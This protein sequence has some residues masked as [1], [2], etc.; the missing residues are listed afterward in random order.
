MI[1]LNVFS[2]CFL[3]IMLSLMG[4]W[5][6]RVKWGQWHQKTLANTNH[7]GFLQTSLTNQNANCLCQQGIN[8]LP[9]CQQEYKWTD[10]NGFR[11]CKC[12][13][14]FNVFLIFQFQGAEYLLRFHSKRMNLWL[15]ML[16]N[17]SRGRREKG[18]TEPY[19]RMTAIVI[20]TTSATRKK[21]CGKSFMQTP[22]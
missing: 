9:L 13:Y 10:T 22:S 17:S 2:V 15:N 20:C 16:V 5:L 21:K 4:W 14:M 11:Y 7:L 6:C 12:M 18:A 3:K 1:S 19:T 8:H